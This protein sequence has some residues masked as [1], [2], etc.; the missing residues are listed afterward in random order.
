MQPSAM[1]YPV[2]VQVALTFALQLWTARERTGAIRRGE[3]KA[4]DIALGQRAWPDR[5][6]QISNAFHNQLELPLLF[7]ALAA[8]ALI[9][10]RVDAVLV[11]LAWA[12]VGLRLWHAY[13]HTTHN[14]VRQRFYVFAVGSG[15]LMAMWAYFA[16]SIVS[17]AA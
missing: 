14:V 5:A 9:M 3:V 11:A 1:L 2:F 10:E 13:I 4:S 7:Y 15:V 12:F 6:T 8:F 16:V 17:A